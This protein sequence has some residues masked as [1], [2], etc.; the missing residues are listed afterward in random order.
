MAGTV[1]QSQ[2]APCSIPRPV[3]PLPPSREMEVAE[4]PV[5]SVSLGMPTCMGLWCTG[6][7]NKYIGYLPLPQSAV[8]DSLLQL[9]YVV[10]IFYEWLHKTDDA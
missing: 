9:Y 10:K 8:V 7:L 3:R 2:A 5:I 6:R 1:H 4:L